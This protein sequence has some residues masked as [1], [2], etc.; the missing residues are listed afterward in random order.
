ALA[1]IGVTPEPVPGGWITLTSPYF[2]YVSYPVAAP[3]TYVMTELSSPFTVWTRTRSPVSMT[4]RWPE[5]PCC[6]LPLSTTTIGGHTPV[7]RNTEPTAMPMMTAATM[8]SRASWI[9]NSQG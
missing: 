5:L 2:V 8:R 4:P 1:M 6:M 3:S 9:A 7:Y